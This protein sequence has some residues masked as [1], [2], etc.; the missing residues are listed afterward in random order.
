MPAASPARF[1]RQRRGRRRAWSPRLGA[2]PMR[3]K[4]ADGDSGRPGLRAP[5]RGLGMS[6]AAGAQGWRS[7][8]ALLPL[9]GHG[10]EGGQCG[11]SIL[12]CGAPRGLRAG[13]GGRRRRGARRDAWDAVPVFWAAG[14]GDQRDASIAP[15]VPVAS[16]HGILPS[17]R[18]DAHT[19]QRGIRASTG[20]SYLGRGHRRRPAVRCRSA[21]HVFS[22]TVPG[23]RGAGMPP[24][25]AP[26]NPARRGAAA[27]CPLP[28]RHCPSDLN[29]HQARQA[30][31]LNA[32]TW[33]EPSHTGF[34]AALYTI[35][36]TP[37]QWRRIPW[38]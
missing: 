35:I 24:A 10:G 21:P 14:G 19:P 7:G 33:P 15:L 13:A 27:A 38:N 2:A 4:P 17:R 32:Y 23:A 9:H 8:A 20:S 11:S 22:I 28:G 25:A 31:D 1:S 30:S 12:L 29:L 16:K 6:P 36:T 5:G 3:E 37:R 26:S 34:S 18:P